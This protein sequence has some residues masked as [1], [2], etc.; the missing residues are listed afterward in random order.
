[1]GLGRMLAIE[2]ARRNIKVNIVS[3][4]AA[5]SMTAAALPANMHGAMSP[6]RVAQLVGYLCHESCATTGEI[7]FATPDA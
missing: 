5:T 3:P 2:G 6:G 4:G 7:F 1:M